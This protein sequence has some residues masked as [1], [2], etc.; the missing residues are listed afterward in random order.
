M[1][2]HALAKI[3][4]RSALLGQ[5][6]RMEIGKRERKEKKTRFLGTVTDPQRDSSVSTARVHRVCEIRAACLS[7]SV[8]SLSISLSLFPDD[9]DVSAKIR[10]RRKKRREIALATRSRVNERRR[11]L[12]D[13]YSSASLSFFSRLSSSTG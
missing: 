9:S 7:E 11:T 1:V 2:A 13:G 3:S 6:V 8:T 12:G 4:A 5:R 10:E